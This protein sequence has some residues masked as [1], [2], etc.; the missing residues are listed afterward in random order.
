MVKA[1]AEANTLF[2]VEIRQSEDGLRG[3]RE[4]G[5]EKEKQIETVH[6]YYDRGRVRVKHTITDV[7]DK[8]LDGTVPCDETALFKPM[9]GKTGLKMVGF[10]IS[11]HSRTSSKASV[12]FEKVQA[13]VSKFMDHD[14]RITWLRQLMDRPYFNFELGDEEFIIKIEKPKLTKT[15]KESIV[16]EV[17]DSDRYTKRFSM[18]YENGDLKLSLIH[19]SGSRLLERLDAKL[20]LRNPSE[21]HRGVELLEVHRLMG[22][23]VAELNLVKQQLEES[24][25]DLLQFYPPREWIRNEQGKEPRAELMIRHA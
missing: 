18:S 15:G 11:P 16:G 14:F 2:G 24:V 8:K 13:D 17:A 4:M 12:N 6:M 10:E 25:R 21:P 20:K 1:L 9:V 22:G 7:E 19:E 5:K 3:T 23:G